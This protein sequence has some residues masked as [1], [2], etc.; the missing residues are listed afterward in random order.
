MPSFVRLLTLALFAITANAAAINGKVLDVSISAQTGNRVTVAGHP[1]LVERAP[2]FLQEFAGT[3]TGE[4]NRDGS[5]EGNAY[6]TYTVLNNATYD[7]AGCINFCN[8]VLGCGGFLSSPSS[9]LLLLR[10]S[11]HALTNPF[12]VF[13]NLY[14][15]F[16]NYD[17]DFVFPEKSNLKCA[18]YSKVHRAFE[19][20]NRGGQQSIPPPAGLTYIQNSSG[21]TRFTG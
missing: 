11:I 13:V 8:S 18:A 7:V 9:P 15:E 2:I 19:K 16:N 12:P 17:L 4:T 20:T 6:L 21:W 10:P 14:Y 5:I 3:G 1:N